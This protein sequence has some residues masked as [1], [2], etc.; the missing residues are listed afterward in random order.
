M[1]LEFIPVHQ[2]LPN[3]E[4]TVHIACENGLLWLGYHEG[5]R[6]FSIDGILESRVL[7]WAYMRGPKS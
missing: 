7:Y 4:C 6:W 1:E 5:D 3:D 2:Q